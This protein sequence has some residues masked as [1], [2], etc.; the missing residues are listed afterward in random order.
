MHLLIEDQGKYRQK[1]E[2]YSKQTCTENI[3]SLYTGNVQ[4]TYILQTHYEQ[5]SLSKTKNACP[6]KKRTPKMHA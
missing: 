4:K 3:H 6:E 1:L 5:A 2:A